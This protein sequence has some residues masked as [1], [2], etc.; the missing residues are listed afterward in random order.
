MSRFR[1][2]IEYDGSRYHGW[3]HNTG[4]KT[5]QGEMV[6]VCEQLFNTKRIEL[7]GAGRTDAGVHALGQV[8]HL[9]VPTQMP[10]ETMIA[11]LNEILPYDIHILKLERCDAGFHARYDAVARSYVYVISRRRSAFG[12]PYVWWVKEDLAVKK[13]QEAAVIF[14]GFHDFSSFGATSG[15]DKSTLV[16]I[17]HLDVSES[18]NLILLH[19]LGSHFLWMMVRRITG[20]L[21]HAGK[22]KLT[23]KEIWGFMNQYSERP[24]QLAAPPSGLY[25]QRVYYPG[26][27]FEYHPKIPVVI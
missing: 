26:E 21:V 9:D 24:S 18:G 4:V 14:R 10:A 15:E 25:L 1:L 27:I 2:L 6:S 12:K 19:I 17:N 7:Y 11:R 3:Q 23:V 22:G 8:A 5:I 16:D 20:V 13:M